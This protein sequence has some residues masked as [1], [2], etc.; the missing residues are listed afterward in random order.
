MSAPISCN[1]GVCLED[2]CINTTSYMPCCGQEMCH[3]CYQRWFF[4]DYDESVQKTCP[5]C[6]EK[7]YSQK[8]E[9]IV[10]NHHAEQGKMWAHYKLGAIYA[11]KDTYRDD[12]KALH[13]YL[14]AADGGE[15]RSLR[16][17]GIL[18][19]RKGEL[20]KSIE[21]WKRGSDIGIEMCS[22]LLAILYFKV[23]TLDEF[24]I[25]KA[26]HY[27]QIAVQQKSCDAYSKLGIWYFDGK[28]GLEVNKTRG[29]ELLTM[30]AKAGHQ[31]SQYL[32]G[33]YYFK[34]DGVEKSISMALHYFTL[35]AVILSRKDKEYVVQMNTEEDE[36]DE[37]HN[38]TFMI[39]ECHLLNDSFVDAYYFFYKFRATHMMSCKGCEIEDVV[40]EKMNLLRENLTSFCSNCKRKKEKSKP[41]AV[42]GGC[43][44]V[45]F[46]SKDCQRAL[47]L[48]HKEICVKIKNEKLSDLMCDSLKLT[49]IDSYRKISQLLKDPKTEKVLKMLKTPIDSCHAVMKS[50][51]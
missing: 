45:S 8:D 44:I 19:C 2:N 36:I 27:M 46:C 23:P 20:N 5:L 31:L 38:A 28:C 32:L 25:S 47:W 40:T 3:S 34:G 1:C 13:H 37:P 42:C 39:A 48:S 18:L 16:N 9:L 24:S 21:Y 29:I 51:K 11:N 17:I 33:F 30:A 12:N 26:V 10:L 14:L 15:L 50:K 49:D 41:L 6:R 43:N 35:A 22:Y 4:N 7:H